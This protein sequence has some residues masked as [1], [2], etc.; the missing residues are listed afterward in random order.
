MELYKGFIIDPEPFR[1]PCYYISPFHAGFL[2]ENKRIV[3]QQKVNGKLLD[4]FFGKH[5]YFT[6][7]G[8]ESIFQA[9]C[10]YKL[11]PSDEVLIVTTTQNKYISTCVTSQIERICRWSRSMSDHTRLIFI[12]HEF[13]YICEEVNQYKTYG[14]PIIEDMAYSLFSGRDTLAG[15]QGDF[16]IYSLPKIFPVQMGGVLRV[17]N[18]EALHYAPV[19]EPAIR[20][21]LRSLASHYLQEADSNIAARLHN[22]AYFRKSIGT[23][24]GTHR[25]ESLSGQVPGAFLFH[26]PQIDL[27]AL[28]VFLQR[29]GI[30]CSVFYGEDCFYLPL[31]QML[32]DSDI[33][34]FILLI[35]YFIQHENL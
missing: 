32:K 4:N 21:A 10:Q 2:E 11:Q 26:L 22:D 3:Q 31:H 7:S 1:K 6:R 18:S 23:V 25:F 29:N 9:L 8:K 16:T 19:L 14:L 33:N 17:N 27:D 13:G 20:K 35:E 15:G 28:K 34:F 12:N 30:E 5:H 24:G